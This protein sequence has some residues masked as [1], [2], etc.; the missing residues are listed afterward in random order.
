MLIIYYEKPIMSDYYNQYKAVLIEKYGW[1]ETNYP[2]LYSYD[3]IYCKWKFYVELEP[4]HPYIQM[5]EKTPTYE[6]Y[7]FDKSHPWYSIAEPILKDF[8]ILYGDVVSK[9]NPYRA[10]CILNIDTFDTSN[11]RKE[12]VELP[13]Y[14][15]EIEKVELPFYAKIFSQALKFLEITINEYE[16][17]KANNN[18]NVDMVD[19]VDKQEYLIT[20]DNELLS[21]KRQRIM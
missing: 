21:S 10:R 5:L 20:N 9:K 16:R 3:V 19:M 17:N 11:E 2:I 15:N 7:G 18:H 12:K 4:T 8:W 6:R 13:F 14:A 1:V